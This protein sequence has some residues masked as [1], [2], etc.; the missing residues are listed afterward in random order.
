[1]DADG[2][3]I[4]GIRLPY[5]EAPL[6]THTGWSLLHEGAG[7][8]DSCGQHGQF[9]PFANTKAERL[10]TGD[11]RPSIE[12]RYENHSEYVRE[13]ARAA[14]RLVREGF[15]LQEDEERIVEEADAKG[16]SLWKTP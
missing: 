15:L 16:V 9:F 4:A 8:P 3:D 2:N 11:P 10:A 5:L 6:G 14:R 13:V 7:F 1:V 12:E